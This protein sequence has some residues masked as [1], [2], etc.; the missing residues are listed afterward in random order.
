MTDA[1]VDAVF[2]GSTVDESDSALDAETTADCDDELVVVPNTLPVGTAVGKEVLECDAAGVGDDFVDSLGAAE[3]LALRVAAALA[4]ADSDLRGDVDAVALTETER[5][6][7]GE[8]DE[9]LLA[10]FDVDA[11]AL[12]EMRGDDDT[13]RDRGAEPDGL[14]ENDVDFVI[15]ALTDDDT[16]ATEGLDEAVRFVE[17]DTSGERD[18]VGLFDMAEEPVR[19]TVAE[20]E[21]EKTPEALAATERVV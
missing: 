6:M 15:A 18:D 14:T 10:L 19:I 9:L 12:L 21:C 8:L 3:V 1:V 17:D 11:D 2:D 13:L 4:L 20:G 5:D 7:S 16:D